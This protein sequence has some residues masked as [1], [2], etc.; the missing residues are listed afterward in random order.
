[1]AKQRAAPWE[2]LAVAFGAVFLTSEPILSAT[3]LAFLSPPFSSTIIWLLVMSGNIL[4]RMEA[5]AGLSS[6]PAG[7]GSLTASAA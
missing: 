1:M 2:S 6:A 4:G 7:N 5:F 3:I